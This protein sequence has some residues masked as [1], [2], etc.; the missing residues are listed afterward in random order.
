M[1]KPRDL[2][3][4]SKDWKRLRCSWVSLK[5]ERELQ[6]QERTSKMPKSSNKLLK[7][8][9]IRSWMSLQTKD[10]H[11]WLRRSQWPRTNTTYLT[12]SNSIHSNSSL[13]LPWTQTRCVTPCS[14]VSTLITPYHLKNQ[15]SKIIMQASNNSPSKELCGL[16]RLPQPLSNN[17]SKRPCGLVKLTKTR[18]ITKLSSI[19]W[20]WMIPECI[21]TST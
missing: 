19:L 11:P 21:I 12:N 6:W 4:L 14:K 3:V 16:V 18:L 2:R 13:E 10:N 17:H 7:I 1:M 20:S 8:L 9:R 5:N 15:E